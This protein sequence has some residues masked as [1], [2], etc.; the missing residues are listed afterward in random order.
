MKIRCILT[1]LGFAI[2]VP[3]A[4]AIMAGIVWIPMAVSIY[5]GHD[6]LWGMAFILVV[7]GAGLGAS[8]CGQEP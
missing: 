3:A 2:V 6:P 8:F 4:L 7:L 5:L 1:V